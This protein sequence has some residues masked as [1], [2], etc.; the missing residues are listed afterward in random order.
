MIEIKS[1]Y[2]GAIIKSIEADTLSR[3]NLS[4][5][6]LSGAY[7]SRA[8]LFWANLSGADLYG[9]DLYGADLYGADLSRA[10][11]SRANLS[12]ANLSGANLYGAD[13]SGADLSGANLSEA[14]L[15]RANL[16]EANLSEANLS[17]SSHSLLGEI[18]RVAAEDSIPRRCFA[19]LVL[20]SRDWCWPEFLA[21]GLPE[22]DWAL[23]TLA[24]FRKVGDGAPEVIVERWGRLQAANAARSDHPEQIDNPSVDEP[25]PPR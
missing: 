21:C 9:A 23:D 14:D 6:Y 5:A 8:N 11:L 4:G 7:L 1:R 17:W 24:V 22:L 19:G 25:P 20:A 10:N 15:S 12:G 13:L 2:T 16:S 18:L 3:A